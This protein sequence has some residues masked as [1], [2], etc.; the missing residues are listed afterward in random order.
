MIKR[1]VKLT[2]REDATEEFLSVFHESKDK[3]R[4][5]PGCQYMEL[6]RQINPNNVFFT[7]SIWDSEEA[8]NAYRH[9][10]V[11]KATWA[12]TKVLFNDRPKA[13][14]TQVIDEPAY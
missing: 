7:L 1:I 14:S 9:S 10:D 13:W 12:K 6:Q 5:F 4:A 11:F 2:F 8:L 3:I